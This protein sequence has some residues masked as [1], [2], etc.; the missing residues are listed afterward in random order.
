MGK[1]ITKS[2]QIT[3]VIKYNNY[4]RID[5]SNYYFSH[6]YFIKGGRLPFTFEKLESINMPAK[7]GWSDKAKNL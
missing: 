5:Y 3:S 6:Y 7:S 1:S 4:F 2:K